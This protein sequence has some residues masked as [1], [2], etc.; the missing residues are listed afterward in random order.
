MRHQLVGA[1]RNRKGREQRETTVSPVTD[2]WFSP[3]LSQLLW[4]NC[5]MTIS[6]WPRLRDTMKRAYEIFYY[7]TVMSLG[8]QFITLHRFLFI[9][10]HRRNFSAFCLTTKTHLSHTIALYLFYGPRI[11]WLLTFFAW[12]TKKFNMNYMTSRKWTYNRQILYINF[13]LF[14]MFST[15][16]FPLTCFPHGLYLISPLKFKV[17][18]NGMGI[19]SGT[20]LINISL[21]SF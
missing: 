1:D 11:M 5:A 4:L 9:G 2:Q 15:F 21:F 7:T 10:T 3:L 16:V 17:A 6:H 12:E 13:S 20:L 19:P 18:S 8:A 14:Y